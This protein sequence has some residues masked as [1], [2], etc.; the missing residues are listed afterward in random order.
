MFVGE[1]GGGGRS[2]GLGVGRGADVIH[3]PAG[4]GF[5]RS[6]GDAADGARP[7]KIALAN[8]KG[9]K[10]RTIFQRKYSFQ[11]CQKKNGKMTEEK[12]EFSGP[13]WFSIFSLF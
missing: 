8:S 5:R 12:A 4:G 1:F 3:A 10:D 9:P 11:I 7:L 2:I 6:F 13:G